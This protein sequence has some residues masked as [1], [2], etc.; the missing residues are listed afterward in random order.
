MTMTDDDDGDDDDEKKYILFLLKLSIMIIIII[1]ITRSTDIAH[2]STIKVLYA[3]KKRTSLLKTR[4]VKNK[5]YNYKLRIFPR[6]RFDIEF[7]S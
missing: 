1:I 4:F 7:A 6:Y 3:K 2:A 5:N